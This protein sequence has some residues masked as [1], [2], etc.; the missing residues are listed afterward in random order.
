MKKKVQIKEHTRRLKNGRVITIKA[1]VVY[2]ESS[3]SDSTN[4]A[5]SGDELQSRM[6][7]RPVKYKQQYALE[8]AKSAMRSG[9]PEDKYKNYV[10]LL[11]AQH[12]SIDSHDKKQKSATSKNLASFIRQLPPK[13]QHALE[14]ET[15]IRW[16]E[17]GG[18]EDV[19]SDT[20]KSKHRYKSTVSDRDHGFH[21][22]D[23]GTIKYIKK[24]VRKPRKSDKITFT[25]TE[26]KRGFKMVTME[27]GTTRVYYPKDQDKK[28]K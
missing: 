22:F 12:Q 24:T 17:R 3:R 13:Q 23:D 21:I 5:K 8:N 2:R 16:L 19:S 7:L 25:N 10:N 27:D 26:R 15:D 28:T 11:L 14:K 18:G 1:H 9:L 4:R 6:K 20:G